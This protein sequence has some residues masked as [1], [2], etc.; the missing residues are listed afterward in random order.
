MLLPLTLSCSSLHNSSHQIGTNDSQLNASSVG[1]DKLQFHIPDAFLDR[2]L[3]MFTRISTWTSTCANFSFFSLAFIVLHSLSLSIVLPS[4]FLG[5]TPVLLNQ[6]LCRW[7]L[8]NLFLD[9]PWGWFLRTL[10]FKTHYSSPC[11]KPWSHTLPSLYH[12]H[13]VGSWILL[14]SFPNT[15]KKNDP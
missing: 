12:P 2:S 10:Q 3:L 8:R 14:R 11:R 7:T 6:D 15:R 4:A 9:K 5:Y 1:S 13:L